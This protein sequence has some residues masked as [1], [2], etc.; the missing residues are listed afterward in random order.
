MTRVVLIAEVRGGE[1]MYAQPP[2]GWAQKLSLDGRRVVRKVRKA[3]L[4]LRTSPRHW[5]EH[6]SIKLKEHGYRQDGRDP[7]LYMNDNLD[8]CIGVRV[9]DLLTDS[10]SEVSISRRVY[11]ESKRLDQEKHRCNLVPCAMLL[12]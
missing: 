4:G 6:L 11:S 3:M 7:C 9:D 2:D 1:Q 8:V 10:R 5:Q 12:P